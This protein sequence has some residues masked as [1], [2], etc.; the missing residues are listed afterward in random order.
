MWLI[1][2]QGG[3]SGPGGSGRRHSDST[4]FEAGAPSV[5]LAGPRSLQRNAPYLPLRQVWIQS[6]VSRACAALSL[7]SQEAMQ[8]GGQTFRILIRREPV[9]GT[10]QLGAP[11]TPS[12]ESSMRTFERKTHISTLVSLSRGST[13][14]RGPE[15]QE[16]VS[17]AGR[18]CP[19]CW[20]PEGPVGRS[21]RGCP[22]PV[23]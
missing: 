14:Q 7:P 10:E 4:R 5:R 21:L 13:H 19:E 12:G 6:T 16:L 3:A 9:Q 15:I 18:V 23:M 17:R 8:S 11:G 20:K 1:R 22:N 2:R